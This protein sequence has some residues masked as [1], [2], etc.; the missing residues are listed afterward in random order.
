MSL[1]APPE[2]RPE[3]GASSGGPESSREGGAGPFGFL[4][5]ALVALFL[6]FGVV[7]PFVA[8]PF[9]ITTGSMDPTLRAGDSAL[10]TKF[11]YRLAGPERGDV[12]LF[13]APGGA[14]TIKRVV[15]LPGDTVAVRDGVLFVNGEKTV[16]GYVDY[17]L[18]DATFFGPT[19]VPEGHVYVMGDNRTQYGSED[20]RMFGVVA[21]DEIVGE[22]FFVNWPLDEIGPIGHGDYGE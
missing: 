22:A 15:G 12:V 11:A 16:E 17:A 20:S 21:T 5:A 2:S 13:E 8:E 18:T 6:V 19:D 14:P 4:L 7:R 10:A 1:A 9:A 3:D